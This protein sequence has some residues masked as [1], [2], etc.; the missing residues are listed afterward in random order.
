MR[1]RKKTERVYPVT[2]FGQFMRYLRR[3]NRESVDI[4]AEKLGVGRSYLSQVELSVRGIY[5]PLYLVKRVDG[6]YKLTPE[7]LDEFRECVLTINS[8]IKRLDF[9]NISDS[10]RKKILSYAYNLMLN[11]EEGAE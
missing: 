5:V 6:V 3:K 2:P 8:D 10:D 4:M 7:E 11:R 9:G 1:I